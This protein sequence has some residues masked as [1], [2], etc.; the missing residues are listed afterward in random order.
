MEK[1]EMVDFLKAIADADR[2][3]IIGLLTQGPACFP[4]IV[5]TLGYHPAATL[6][7]LERLVQGGLVRLTEG[8][9][10]LDTQALER[11]SQRQFQG[12]RPVYSPEAGTQETSTRVLAAHLNPDGTIKSIPLQKAKL[13]VILNYV[14]EAFSLDRNYTEKEINAIISQFHPDTAGLRRDLVEAGMLDRVRDGSRYW[15]II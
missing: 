3:R 12:R 15:R 14:I 13:H 11:F 10:V 1:L 5:K 7:H 2:L 8:R 9:Y 6:R 4:D